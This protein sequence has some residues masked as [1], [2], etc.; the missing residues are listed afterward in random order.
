MM[1]V[2]KLVECKT[3]EW[4]RKTNRFREDKLK[5]LG[6]RNSSET[7]FIICIYVWPIYYIVL[8]VKH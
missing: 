6:N 4:E 3:D 8:L 1:E 7:T 2:R 5:A